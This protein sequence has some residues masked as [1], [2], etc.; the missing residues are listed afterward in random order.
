MRKAGHRLICDTPA[1]MAHAVQTCAEGELLAVDIETIPFIPPKKRLKSQKDIHLP[2]LMTVCSYS[3]VDSAGGMS[4]FGFQLVKE[5]SPFSPPAPRLGEVLESIQTIN[6][7]PVP[8]T[9]HNGVYDAAWFIR[10]GTPLIN[11]AYDSMT[12]W[13]ARYPDLPKTLDF[14]S[15]I[16]LDDYQYWKMGRKETDLTFHTLYAMKDTESTLRNTLRLLR[17]LAKDPAMRFNFLSAHNRCLAGL[18]MSMRGAAVDFEVR[19][20]M[21]EELKAEAEEKLERFRF[22]VDNPDFN[23]QSPKQMGEL[24]YGVLGARPRNAKGRELVRVTKRAKV[25]T[26]E[27]ALR[28]IQHEH[29]I[30]GHVV[31]AYREVRVPAKQISNVIGIQLAED[32]RFRT[33]YDGIG[34]TTSRF[35]SRSDAFGFGSNA[36]NIRKKY[37]RMIRADANSALWEV[38]FS[39]ADDVFVSYESEDEKKIWVVESG[40]DIHSFNAA[41]VF[42]TN[43]DYDEVVYGN[44]PHVKDPRIV[45]PITGI[46]QITKKVTHGANYLMAG[47]TLLLSAGR[48]AIVAAAVALGH[49]SAP[50]WDTKRLAQFCEVMDSKYR[51]FYPR[52]Q[53]SG[54]QSFY[55]KLQRQLM[56]S[57]GFTTCFNYTQRFINDPRDQATLRAAA[58]TAGQAN[59]AGRVNM[60]MDELEHGIRIAN[61]RDGPAPDA[62][63][64]LQVSEAQNGTTPVFQTHDSITFNVNFA[65]P[66]WR[67]GVSNVLT[68]MRRP[69][70]CKGRVIHVDIE[71]DIGIHWAHNTK[72]ASTLEAVEA[73]FEENREAV[74]VPNP[75]NT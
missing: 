40:K 7:N 52:F 12:M 71:G 18:G 26:G 33:A 34:T 68:V 1:D 31:R 35:S 17:W 9:L 53:R 22:I 54:S 64:A 28:G 55:G 32:G 30:L 6:A 39:G 4:S 2:Y 46:R 27:F 41:E 67:E 65:H 36:Q 73:W 8:K 60:A 3:V 15:S 10:Y 24:L 23:P 63:P 74:L 70:P 57:G 11:Y 13:W 21:H 37:R 69:V 66:N 5:K 62:G 20:S 44:R 16:L 59:T 45:H 58:A 47:M 61:F 42:F 48:D 75:S 25:S 49:D 72:D 38:D 19:E 14:V 43:W 50:T 51:S 56:D 29:P